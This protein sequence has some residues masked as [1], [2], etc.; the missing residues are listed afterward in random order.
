MLKVEVCPEADW[1]KRQLQNM[2]LLDL[3]VERLETQKTAEVV[4]QM[5]P[6]PT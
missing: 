1:D 2:M 3:M 6:F 4:R 5:W